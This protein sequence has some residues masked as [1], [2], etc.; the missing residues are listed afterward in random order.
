MNAN[1]TNL[2]HFKCHI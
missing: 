1:M 2:Y